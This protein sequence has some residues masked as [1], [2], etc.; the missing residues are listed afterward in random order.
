MYAPGYRSFHEP[1]GTP[2]ARSKSSRIPVAGALTPPP[3][4]PSPP[5][6]PPSPPVPPAP[7]MPLLALA[8]LA[9][10]PSGAPVRP[11]NEEV[12]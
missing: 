2:S 5:A 12:R 10:S 7:P 11:S 8:A 3:A 9:A 6:P 1:P 4:P